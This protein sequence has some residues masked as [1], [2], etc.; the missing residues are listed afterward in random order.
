MFYSRKVLTVP[1]T[2]H[3]FSVFGCVSLALHLACH[4]PLTTHIPFPLCHG[5]Y[6]DC[7]LVT[8]ILKTGSPTWC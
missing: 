1:D 5:P 7:S 8:H 4:C 6:L 2:D 3:M